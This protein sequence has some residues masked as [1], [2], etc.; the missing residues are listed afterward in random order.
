MSHYY[1]LMISSELSA[2][3]SKRWRFWFESC[4]YPVE[5]CSSF[6]EPLTLNMFI[7]WTFVSTFEPKKLHGA[8]FYPKKG[9][10]SVSPDFFLVISSELFSAQW[11]ISALFHTSTLFPHCFVNSVT[12]WLM[13]VLSKKLLVKP[14]RWRFWFES[15]ETK[16]NYPFWALLSQKTSWGI[17]FV[18]KVKSPW[19]PMIF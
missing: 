5:F 13:S 7:Q 17:I 11:A 9:W 19:A 2:L 4:G 12:R 16:L 3:K 6:G 1:F 14:K 15:F 10:A 8:H 18:L